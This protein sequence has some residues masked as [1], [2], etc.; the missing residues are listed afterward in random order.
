MLTL[1][2]IQVVVPFINVGI[3]YIIKYGHRLFLC[4]FC[5]GE[6]TQVS[7]AGQ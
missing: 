4:L 5:Q 6:A 3:E 7:A 2:Y 1:L